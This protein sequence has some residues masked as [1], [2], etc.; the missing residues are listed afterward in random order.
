MKSFPQG[1]IALV[2]ALFMGITIVLL[3]STS[4]LI[5]GMNRRGALDLSLK[6]QSTFAAHT[7]LERAL[8]NLART[9]SYAGNETITIDGT[10]CTIGALST[11]GGNKIISVSSTVNR[12]TTNLR[13]TVSPTLETLSLTEY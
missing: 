2:T 3:A 12:S 6:S 5:A 10:V 4:A 13:A 8:L 11:S 9:P 7:C 1:Y